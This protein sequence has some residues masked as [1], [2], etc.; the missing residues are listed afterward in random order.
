VRS[1]Q[2]RQPIGMNS[3]LLG[4]QQ[5]PVSERL[6]NRPVLLPAARADMQR[7]RQKS[8]TAPGTHRFHQP[9]VLH[10]A[11]VRKPVA[12]RPLRPTETAARLHRCG[13]KMLRRESMGIAAAF[14][15]FAAYLPE[16]A[17]SPHVKK[18]ERRQSQQQL[19]CSAESLARAGTQ[20]HDSRAAERSRPSRPCFRRQQR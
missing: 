17:T 11:D 12:H 6:T 19:R 7:P 18:E 8:N 20:S 15:R 14:F 5:A 16:P 1:V 4:G 9:N 13:D 3:K 10:Q 2:I